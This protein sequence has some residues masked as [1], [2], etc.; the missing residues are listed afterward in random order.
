MSYE[1]YAYQGTKTK[2]RESRRAVRERLGTSSDPAPTIAD[3]LDAANSLDWIVSD[4]SSGRFR[5]LVLDAR[6]QTTKPASA[7]Y[8]EIKANHD[9]GRAA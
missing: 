1:D 7:A 6:T 4:A 9:A 5:L 2:R 8:A 3:A